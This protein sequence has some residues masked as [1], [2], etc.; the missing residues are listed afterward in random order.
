MLVSVEFS[1]IHAMANSRQI[2]PLA[3]HQFI[4]DPPV[5]EL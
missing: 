3:Q 4:H 1:K 2:C 5:L